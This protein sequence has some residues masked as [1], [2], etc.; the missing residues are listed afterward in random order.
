MPDINPSITFNLDYMMNLAI[1]H[2]QELPQ[3]SDKVLIARLELDHNTQ[4]VGITVLE[5]EVTE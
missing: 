1:E 5:A 3:F 4:V 2:A